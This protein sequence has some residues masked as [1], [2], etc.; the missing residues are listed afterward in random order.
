M[1]SHNSHNHTPDEFVSLDGMSL[2]WICTIL[3]VPAIFGVMFLPHT[4]ALVALAVGV[5]VA[6]GGTIFHTRMQSPGRR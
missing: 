5:V 6:V 4:W 3:F 1:D 2:I